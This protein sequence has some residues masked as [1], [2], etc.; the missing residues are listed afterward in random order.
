MRKAKSNLVFLLGKIDSWDAQLGSL[1]FF[2]GF[3]S[4]NKCCLQARIFCTSK[5]TTTTR[6][7][8]MM[9]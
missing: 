9:E 3:P 2:G 1:G 5:M 7:G 4:P 8:V 6:G